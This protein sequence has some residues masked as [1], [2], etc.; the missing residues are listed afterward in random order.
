[1]TLVQLN[2][3]EIKNNFNVSILEKV[4]DILKSSSIEDTEGLLEGIIKDI[5]GQIKLIRITDKTEGGWAT[6][7]EYQTSD[8]AEDSDDDK[9]ICQAN[10]RALQKKRKLQ[11]S[12]S[13]TC[14]DMG[15]CFS[16]SSL[17]HIEGANS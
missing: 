3:Q 9:K 4:K 15:N 7:E 13:L 14:G 11:H 2:M 5:E 16:F 12:P 6:V 10:T 17:Q 8:L 1:M